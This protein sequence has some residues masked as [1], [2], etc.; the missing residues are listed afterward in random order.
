[1]GVGKRRDGKGKGHA[2]ICRLAILYIVSRN[3]KREEV[4]KC[5]TQASMRQTTKSLSG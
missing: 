5:R 1:M 3:G 2:Q 4:V